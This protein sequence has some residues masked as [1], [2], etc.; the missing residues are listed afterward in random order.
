[1]LHLMHASHTLLVS[2]LA[3]IERGIIVHCGGG[4]CWPRRAV[5]SWLAGWTSDWV[6]QDTIVPTTSSQK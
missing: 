1:M 3:A 2:I 4:G 6:T 5:P